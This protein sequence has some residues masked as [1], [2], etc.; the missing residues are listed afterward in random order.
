M[1]APQLPFQSKPH[2]SLR[3]GL[4]ALREEVLPKHPVQ[5]IQEQGLQQVCPF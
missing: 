2:D 1:D 4:P 3:L 5:L